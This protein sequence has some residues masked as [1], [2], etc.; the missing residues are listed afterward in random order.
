MEEKIKVYINADSDYDFWFNSFWGQIYDD[1]IVIGIPEKLTK[2]FSFISNKKEISTININ[3]I[4]E[5]SIV[6][7][8]PFLE[9]KLSQGFNEFNISSENYTFFSNVPE[10]IEGIVLK[11]AGVTGFNGEKLTGLKTLDLSGN[12]LTFASEVVVPDGC[13]IIADNQA[14]IPIIA[15][16]VTVDLSN[17]VDSANI[18]WKKGEDA[19]PATDYQQSNGKYFFTKNYEGIHAELTDKN[20]DWLKLCTSAVT[21]DDVEEDVVSLKYE[22]FK[23]GIIHVTVSA[24]T[25]VNGENIIETGDI[26]LP[27]GNEFTLTANH[28]ENIVGLKINGVGLTDFVI[29]SLQKLK[30]LDVSDNSLCFDILD[31]ALPDDCKLTADNQKKIGIS[32]VGNS[33]DLSDYGEGFTVRWLKSNGEEITAYD[34]DGGKYSFAANYDNIHAEISKGGLKISTTD[35]SINSVESTAAT[36]TYELSESKTITISTNQPTLINGKEINEEGT[37]DLPAVSE[38]TLTANHPENIIRLDL[39]GIG[40]TAIEIENLPGLK[41]LDVSDNALTFETMPTVPE[42]CK[43]TYGTQ[44]PVEIKANGATVDLSKYADATIV[45]KQGETVVSADKYTINNGVYAFTENL[46]GIHAELTKGELTLTTT[47][48]SI[49]T[50]ESL[51]ATLTCELKEP[52]LITIKTSA[53]TL[54]NGKEIDG[55]GSIELPAGSEFTLTANHPENIIGLDVSGIGL[56]AIEIENLPGLKALD[57]SDNALTF[58]T[59]PTVP[60]GCKVTYG[61]Q[62]PVEIK[63]NGATVDLSKYADATI[64][65]KQGET[66]VSADKYTINNGVYAF[67]ENLEG[68]HAELTKGELTLT[69]TKISINTLEST[70]AALAYELAEPKT[71]SVTT[72]QPTLVNGKEINGEG[73]IDLSAGSE[74][75][76]TANHP[77]NIIG[78][79]LSGIGL[80]RIDLADLPKLKALNLNDNALDIE[81]PLPILPKDCD[82]TANNQKSIEIE[83]VGAS[84]DLSKYQDAKIVWKQNYITV[85][86]YTVK[87]GIYTFKKNFAG[88]HAELTKS[89]LAVKTSEITIDVVESDVAAISYH[90]DEPGIIIYTLSAPTIINGVEMS[91]TAK[92]VLPAGESYL[93]TANHPENIAELSL[94]NIGLR[95]MAV[96]RLPN[97]KKLDLS[98]NELGFESLPIIPEECEVIAD[99]QKPLEIRAD[100]ANIDMT[101]YYLDAKIS[102]MLCDEPF[103][104]FD[105]K[106]GVYTFFDNLEGLYAVVT[107][108]WLTRTTV[109]VTIDIFSYEAAELSYALDAPGEIGITT[110]GPTVIND[111]EVDGKGVITLPAGKKLTLTT[112]HPE[113]IIGLTIKG[114]GLTHLE[115]KHMPS[116]QKLT[117][118]GDDLSFDHLPVIPSG[119]NVE[120]ENE[121][122]ITIG[123]DGVAV[124]LSAYPG[125]TVT[126]TDG[127]NEIDGYEESEGIYTFT[128]DYDG[129]YALLSKDWLT[130]KTSPISV[131]VSETPV[132]GLTYSRTEPGE[133]RVTTSAPTLICGT[134]VNGEATISIPAG[135]GYTLAANFPENVKE[136]DVAG[137]GL[138]DIDIIDLPALVSI[139]LSGN[140][141][142]FDHIPDLP[143]TCMRIQ[144]AD[145]SPIELV[146][147]GATI[148][149]SDYLGH[150]IEW[151]DADHRQLSDEHYEHT[152]GMYTFLTSHSSLHAHITHA[153]YP[154]LTLTTVPIDVTATQLIK[155]IKNGV[156]IEVANRKIH[157]FGDYYQL[158]LHDLSGRR[159]SEPL[160]REL[161]PG[162]YILQ[163]DRLRQKLLIK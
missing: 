147:D 110:S 27:A 107:R 73:T 25:I 23:P 126:W 6:S 55:E 81:A 70:A 129:I 45:W 68:I 75:T 96:F 82:V 95:E 72:N 161:P 150:I 56:T 15:D 74:F 111:K 86:D 22:L 158:S 144:A 141:L 116:F 159:I 145:Q 140:A 142:D 101:P 40:L 143:E 97:M 108:D 35:I 98:E 52:K 118:Y 36:L 21:I 19:V 67:T 1:C 31:K 54:V 64:V 91:G 18:V 79:D 146:A 46:E 149:L 48:I 155:I 14:I 42:G 124:D 39:S 24:P 8:T 132:A 47:K 106:S 53:P 66:V 57:V 93:L 78:L 127:E 65:W 13:K 88:L 12:N 63:A 76:L 120:I 122:T 41:A 20:R 49:N 50:L 71:I 136:L 115:A 2:V 152:D 16:G 62:E 28:P 103:N 160:D 85:N 77:E 125:V 58:E 154:W 51:A 114:I 61:T 9:S 92:A 138:T 32:V 43:V 26:V 84:V 69:T 4:N 135:E 104:D 60:E 17:Y 5:I 30:S 100:G 109:P 112:N 162:V 151:H 153:S 3:T 123:V 90:L 33:V 10:A 163:I 131:R 37:I 113:R 156:R 80:T 11:D 119:C 59:M 130:M 83:A 34:A 99:N 87:D 102:W 44:E 157:I 117:L 148:D 133:I 94:R 134:Y 137:I 7:L 38:F 128:Q 105:L 139:D 89:W 121:R 29:I